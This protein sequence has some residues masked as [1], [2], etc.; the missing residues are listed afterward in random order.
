MSLFRPF[1]SWPM[2]GQ[3]ALVTSLV[4]LAVAASIGAGAVITSRAHTVKLVR[5]DLTAVAGIMADRLGRGVEQRVREISF[6][7]ELEPI[8]GNW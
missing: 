5:A 7:A 8:S 2:R 4:G 6:L 3:I 1:S